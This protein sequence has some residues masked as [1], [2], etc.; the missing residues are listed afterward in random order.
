MSLRLRQ[1]SIYVLLLLAAAGSAV[2]AYPRLRPGPVALHRAEQL[3]A[4]GE[5]AAALPLLREAGQ[6]RGLTPAERLRTASLLRDAGDYAVAETLYQGLLRTNVGEEARFRLAE[7]MAW[8]GQ[9]KQA[10]ELCQEM[11]DRDPKDRR[12]RLLLARVLSWDG[13]MEESIGQYRMLLGETP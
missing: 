13:R 11:L 3:L 7:T 1:M 5:T 4:G 12:A 9:F 6:G 2:W 10:G 8:A